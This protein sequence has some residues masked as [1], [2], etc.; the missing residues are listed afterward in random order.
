MAFFE[1]RRLAVVE[2][3]IEG[4]GV[5]PVDVGQAERGQVVGE[6]PEE[7]AVVL[8]PCVWFVRCTDISDFS[9]VISVVCRLSDTTMDGPS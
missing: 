3:G 2:G 4:I 8:G 9:I 6:R 5:D 7:P 1:P